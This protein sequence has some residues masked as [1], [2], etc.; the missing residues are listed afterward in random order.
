MRAQGSRNPRD[1][2]RRF[3]EKIHLSEWAAP[4]RASEWGSPERVSAAAQNSRSGSLHN[5]VIAFLRD[6]LD[7]E[8]LAADYL[9]FL[10]AIHTRR[11]YR[12]VRLIRGKD[13]NEGALAHRPRQESAPTISG[14]WHACHLERREAR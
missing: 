13:L 7:R 6:G 11:I 8:V 10:V 4:L 14:T 12:L 5:E 1:A 9:Q 2:E 3:F